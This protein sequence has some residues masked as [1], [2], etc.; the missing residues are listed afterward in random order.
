[1]AL[2]PMY[3]YK[4]SKTIFKDEKI[5]L[6]WNDVSKTVKRT[7]RITWDPRV[8]RLREAKLVVTAKPSSD[9]N[10]FDAYLDGSNVV[11]LS[12]DI[13]DT[14]S[15]T[16]SRDVTE[17]IRNGENIF[18]CSFSKFHWWPT[19]VY[20]VFTEIVDLTYEVVEGAEP[21]K[22]PE[23]T[24]GGLTTKEWAMLGLAVV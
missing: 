5:E 15:K 10:Y 11:H 4:E 21:P 9:R 13:G 16:G 14:A 19:G 23:E 24:K 20:V 8:H 7:V 22:P 6:G 18:E 1:M 3:E 17:L 12:W 2:K